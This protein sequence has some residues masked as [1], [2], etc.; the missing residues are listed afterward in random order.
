MPPTTRALWLFLGATAEHRFVAA[1]GGHDYE[2]N[3]DHS[4]Q[5]SK[6]LITSTRKLFGREGK[7][8]AS[9]TGSKRTRQLAKKKQNVV[10]D[11]DQEEVADDALDLEYPVELRF[12]GKHERRLDAE[13]KNVP[14]QQHP[15]LRKHHLREDSDLLNVEMSVGSRTFDVVLR[16]NRNLL[17]A[18]AKHVMHY[19]NGRTV[20]EP[21]ATRNCYYQGDAVEKGD[22]L[23]STNKDSAPLR[24]LLAASTCEDGL[25][26]MLRLQV[27]GEATRRVL[28]LK[29]GS[30][31]TA[32][33]DKKLYKNKGEQ[34]EVSTHKLRL[35][36]SERVNHY[37]EDV[38]QY[39]SPPASQTR[40]LLEEKA[41]ADAISDE[42]EEYTKAKRKVVKDEFHRVT[43]ATYEE[44]R[45]SLTAAA[46]TKYVEALVVNDKTRYALFGGT[47][48]NMN[49]M[50][51][52]GISVMNEVNTM[53]VN[54]DS[55]N[56][57]T[58]DIRIVLV[59]MHTY[60][61]ADPYEAAVEKIGSET[62]VGSLLDLFN[63]WGR[64]SLEAGTLQHHDNRVLL[65]GRDFDGS[66]IG[67]AG[68]SAMCKVSQ[69]G[70]INM[71]KNGASEVTDCA[72][73]V[74]HELGHNFGMNHDGSGSNSACPTS[75]FVMEAVGN[76]NPNTEF[77]SC[78][79]NNI[80]TFFANSYGDY[81][82]CIENP[83]TQV[84]GDPVCRNGLVEAGED[85]DC[86]AADCSAKDPCCNGNTCRF[87]QPTYQCSDATG[88]CCGSCM[89]RNAS[90][91]FVCRAKKNADCDIAET[92]AGG[93]Q[94]CPR[95]TYIYPGKACTDTHKGDSY[96]GSCM[97][98]VCGSM[99][100]TCSVDVQNMFAESTQK[101]WDMSTTCERYN[102]PC[103]TVVCHEKNTTETTC[104]QFFALHGKQM[105]VPDGMPCW[106]KSNPW[107]VRE[108]MCFGGKCTLP[109][110]LA[111]SGVC[112]N[113]GIDFGEQCDCGDGGALADP[114]CDCA[115]CRLKAGKVCSALETC[116]DAA[117]CQYKTAGTVCRAAV[118]AT[119]D[120][121]ETCSGSSGICPSDTGKLWGTSCTYSDGAASTCYA[122]KCVESKNAQCK[123]V[124]SETDT[125][126]DA[127][128]A[129]S[130]P[131][132]DGSSC[133]A[134]TCC[135]GLS[136]KNLRTSRI[137]V[138]D[139]V[140][141]TIFLGG[142]ITGTNMVNGDE[143]LDYTKQVP[144][145]KLCIRQ[146]YFTPKTA[147]DC[148]A[149]LYFEQSIGD[150][151]ACDSACATDCTG[152]GPFDCVGSCANNAAKDSRGM[153]PPF[154]RSGTT[155]ATPAETA[156][157]TTTY[158]PSGSTTTTI[159]G[160]ATT[161][162]AT[163]IASG[164]GGNGATTIAASATT[165][166]GSITEQAATTLAATSTTSLP[167][168][169]T[170][171]TTT[172]ATGT[173][174]QKLTTQMT[175]PAGA[176]SATLLNNTA[177]VG[178]LKSGIASMFEAGGISESD[179]VINSI[180]V[181]SRRQ[182]YSENGELEGE[183]G[184][185]RVREYIDIDGNNV[186]ER[187][188]NLEAAEDASSPRR[189]LATKGLEIDYSV[190]AT[191]SNEAAAIVSMAA[192]N[193]T[194]LSSRFTTHVGA[195]ITTAGIASDF[196]A[197][198]VSAVA[199]TSSPNAG[200]TASPSSSSA[201]G[202]RRGSST[203]TALSLLLAYIG[204]AWLVLCMAGSSKWFG[205]GVFGR[206]RRSVS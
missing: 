188:R 42:N 18:T 10:Q 190:V 84:L 200:S 156:A 93:T 65:S 104:G 22:S 203:S 195:A 8:V 62:E 32:S 82:L 155:S 152:P 81:G 161:T 145:S 69:S 116:C 5:H 201:F 13:Q 64:S 147:S 6:E 106:H 176:T 165:V 95:D 141:N 179:I 87:A 68:V 73:V 2:D 99:N 146:E 15:P 41:N 101:N 11:H 181:S 178:A 58:Y 128:Y 83:P 48:A 185:V 113:G 134:L 130:Q 119:C 149:N 7:L 110:A 35:L 52:H 107:D 102:D 89:F 205:G 138:V 180:T 75:G 174:R 38:R 30:S 44:R 170:T 33:T 182:L 47:A 34:D 12:I 160:A 168:T 97:V 109:S 118:D 142:A 54:E 131:D 144:G 111:V 202:G 27:P 127:Y 193:S 4:K 19:A 123:R 194:A 61:D 197:L 196:A 24:G 66:T 189:S 151:V 100:K 49:T 67:L 114:C 76:G 60:I 98:G 150:C 50:K 55:S 143:N 172:A 184:S 31:P 206:S 21:L 86:G 159:A 132:D 129:A 59:G 57:F 43:Y 125:V 173:Y 108:G 169:T 139:G 192:L 187:T 94:E 40:Q 96:S 90:E 79:T 140:R 28:T 162:A 17:P 14:A 56:G 80:N 103:G 126:R 175:V 117:T 115:T 167:T 36:T 166:S 137:F 163:T 78:S 164:S 88:P 121:E 1:H 85:C 183:D 51:D 133:A 92:C 70:N 9:T 63:E 124:T 39:F 77:S 153:C 46:T 135:A 136:C 158:A 29:Q 20:E 204:T 154:D 122:K 45:R 198:S 72:A 16:K 91:N 199:T 120:T 112:G 37:V 3:A 74:A 177:F 186:I 191:D 53:Y 26:G 23:T 171:T 148:G 105:A 71:C 25:S 157:P